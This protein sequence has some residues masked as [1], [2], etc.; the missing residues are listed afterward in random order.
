MR[1]ASLFIAWEREII[2]PLTEDTW[3][4]GDLYDPKDRGIGYLR[5]M[6]EDVMPSEIRFWPLDWIVDRFTCLS[7]AIMGGAISQ[8]FIMHDD[9]LLID[10]YL[11]EMTRI[12]SENGIEVKDG[13][14][15]LAEQG[16]ETFNPIP[17]ERQLPNC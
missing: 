12:I 14:C 5:H 15:N 10:R 16:C 6:M 11:M 17:K 2:M 13:I 9:N 8:G 7:T 3:R 4:S 1:V